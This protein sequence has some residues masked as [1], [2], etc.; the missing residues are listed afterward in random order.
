[1]CQQTNQE[2]LPLVFDVSPELLNAKSSAILNGD[3][4]FNLSLINLIYGAEMVK[5]ANELKFSPMV[6]DE[7]SMKA[8]VSVP[9][10]FDSFMALKPQ[11]SS[12]DLILTLES[13]LSLSKDTEVTYSREKSSLQLK[14]PKSELD[15][16]KQFAELCYREKPRQIRI[17]T[18]LL[19]IPRDADLFDEKINDEPASL[20]DGQVL[21]LMRSVSGV[22]GS[23]IST[24]PS[25]VARPSELAKIDIFR[26][27]PPREFSSKVDW[28]GVKLQAKPELLGLSISLGSK[29]SLGE[30]DLFGRLNYA[31]SETKVTLAD[32]FNHVCRIDHISPESK[33]ADS[34][35]SPMRVTYYRQSARNGFNY[36]LVS[37]A[38]IIDATG[39]SVRE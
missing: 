18:K 20:S 4:L 29:I 7:E 32:G 36:Y 16:V 24:L 35:L 31:E 12:R 30:S 11:S 5:S 33:P 38:N 26:E 19:K 37:S 6:T 21:M 22:S 28:V 13:L 3:F 17:S 14:G 1:M 27:F 2:V 25:I 23:T 8:T 34:S 9:P 39:K 10:N 15:R